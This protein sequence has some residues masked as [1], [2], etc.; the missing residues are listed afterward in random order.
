MSIIPNARPINQEEVWH[1]FPFAFA[2]I[3]LLGPDPANGLVKIINM[4]KI[5]IAEIRVLRGP[6]IWSG[7]R[8]ELIQMRVNLGIY[9][10]MPTNKIKG[11]K[12]R[13]ESL[14]P[15]MFEHE[16]SE[17]KPGGFFE[18]VSEGTWLGH[19]AEHIALELQSLAGMECGYG[20]TRSTRNKGE[21]HIVFAYQVESAGIYAGKAAIRIVQALADYQP[22]SIEEDI[23]EL[24]RLRIRDGLDPWALAILAEARKRKIPFQLNNKNSSML[25]GQGK[26]QKRIQ[27][28]NNNFPKRTLKQEA[29][30]LLDSLYPNKADSRIPLIAVTGTN[31]KTTTTRLIAHFAKQAGYKTGYITTDGIFVGDIQIKEGDCSGPSSARLLLRQAEIDFAVLECARG[32]ILRSG[33]G[34]DTCNT[35][36][37]TN[38]T[39]DHLGMEGI[40]SLKDLAK[41]KAVVAKSTAD[42]GWTILNADDDHVYNMRRELDCNMALF[43]LQENNE[44]VRRHCESGGLAAIIEK[45][46]FIVYHGNSRQP[47]AR[48]KEVPLTLQGRA[49][50]MVQNILGAILAAKVHAIPISLI[51]EGLSSFRPSPE[52]TPGRFN[53]FSIGNISVMVD[54]AHNCDGFRHLEKFM[55]KTS[56]S[57]KI[58]IITSPGDRRDEDITRIGAYAARMFDEI[59]IRHDKDLRG[60]TKENITALLLEGIQN[61]NCHLPVKI[62]SDESEALKW[63][64][65]KAPENAFIVTCTEEVKKSLSFLRQLQKSE[66]V[67]N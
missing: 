2:A 64:I 17:N 36:V 62:I 19:V 43:S 1:N 35:S 44:R 56:A 28:S 7:Y 50:C 65:E 49:E 25:V 66:A 57:V 51:K 9:E 23:Q 4:E 53:I 22:Y 34:F 40:H 33:L 8:K 10:E 30:K 13:L 39:D 45:D 67:L 24:K 48:V 20:R 58:G 32:G 27:L 55:E 54:Y 31:G 37:I 29:V 21:Y 18:R 16:C 5:E 26:L 14:L 46:H 6:N 52:L 59:I 15:S 12:E 41:V 60:R 3:S 63:V 38:V 11:F 42:D 47:I 61:M